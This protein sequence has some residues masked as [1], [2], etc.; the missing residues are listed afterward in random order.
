MKKRLKRKKEKMVRKEIHNLLDVILDINGIC[1]RRQ[2]VS[3]NLPTAFFGFSGHV[4]T[5]NFNVHNKGWFCGAD[6][7]L[8]GCVDLVPAKLSAEVKRLKNKYAGAR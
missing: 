4:A 2:E 1:E 6:Y 3:G 8:S 5:V 7:D